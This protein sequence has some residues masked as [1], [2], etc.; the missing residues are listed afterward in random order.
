MKTQQSLAVEKHIDILLSQ[1][2]RDTPTLLGY[3]PSYKGKLKRR[4]KETGPSKKAGGHKKGRGQP[5]RSKQ[6]ELSKKGKEPRVKFPT[7]RR[8]PSSGSSRVGQPIFQASI[9]LFKPSYLSLQRC[10]DETW[11]VSI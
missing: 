11:F 7:L 9:H 6:P 5:G 3:V 8:Q 4:E 2:V 1:A 10:P